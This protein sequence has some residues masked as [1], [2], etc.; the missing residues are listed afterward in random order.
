MH[1]EHDSSPAELERLGDEIATLAADLH[2][3]TYR[4]LT[5]V[6]EFDTRGGWGWG[7]LSCAQWLSWRTGIAPGAAREKV[8]VAR[9]LA[10]LPRISAA[11]RRGELS[12]AKVRAITRVGRPR[13]KRASSTSPSPARPHTSSGLCERGVA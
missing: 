6:R 2:A 10:S 8:R 7:F 1:T 9:A 5:R 13:T 11:M 12:Y 4:L 3:V